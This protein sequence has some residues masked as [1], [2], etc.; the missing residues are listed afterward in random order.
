MLNKRSQ[1]LPDSELSA[2]AKTGGA[3]I[4]KLQEEFQEASE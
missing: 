3:A 2:V 1:L 4:A